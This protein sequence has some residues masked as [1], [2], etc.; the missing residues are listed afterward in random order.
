MVPNATDGRTSS[1]DGSAGAAAEPTAD[2]FDLLTR[3]E[4]LHAFLYLARTSV[5]TLGE[6]A[7][8]IA[9]QGGDTSDDPERIAITLHYGYL[10]NLTVAG[11]VDYDPRAR[12]VEARSELTSVASY[13]ALLEVRGSARP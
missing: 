12:V 8:W 6:T 5:A 4:R 1:S 11:L 2:M 7:E 3:A 9:G 13:L 10:P